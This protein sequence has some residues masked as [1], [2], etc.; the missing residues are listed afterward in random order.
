MATD[1]AY[2]FNRSVADSAAPP[3][4][5]A[6]QWASAYAPPTPD[7]KLLNLAQG[8][9][10]DPPPTEFLARLARAAQDPATTGYGDLR[11]D[12]GLRQEL[13]NDVGQT[14]EGEVSRDDVVITAGCNIAFYSTIIALCQAGDEVILPTPWYFNHEMV[15]K[16]LSIGLV[17][18]AAHPPTFLPSVSLARSLV[19]PKTKAIVLVTPNNPTG[20]IYPK[21]LLREFATLA[22]EKGLALVLDETYRDFV[23]GRPHDL[24]CDADWRRY[25]IHLFSFSKSYA[26]PGHRLGA[27]VASPTFHQQL[28]KTLDC[29][30]ICPARPAQRVLEWAIEGTREWRTE[31]RREL[32]RRQELFRESLDTVEG[33]QVATGS[34]YFAYVQHPFEGTSSESV[35][36]M[37]ASQVGVVA[38]P[39][40]FFSP[41]FAD[42]NEDRYIRFSIANVSTEVLRQVPARLARLNELWPTLELSSK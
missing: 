3:I 7:H 1:P 25:M 36:R 32:D 41:P 8:V 14:Y 23:E 38:L 34:D 17:P 16:Q 40:T 26:I 42:I 21:E 24:F 31:T 28:A 12:L 33:W 35:A 37:L 4:P 20:S 39:G 19:T 18:L 10:G 5:L 22:V 27:V 30:Q 6:T 15:L 2:H 29:L 13:A 11:G 9:P